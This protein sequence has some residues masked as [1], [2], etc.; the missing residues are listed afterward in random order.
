MGG[1]HE[2]VYVKDVDVDSVE[3]MQANLKATKGPKRKILARTEVSKEFWP[4]SRLELTLG[5]GARERAPK[6]RTGA[7]LTLLAADGEYRKTQNMK[8]GEKRVGDVFYHVGMHTTSRPVR[9]LAQVCTIVIRTRSASE[10][11]S[12]VNTYTS[13]FS[14]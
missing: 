10:I 11:P 12:W 13:I 4:V 7:V 8:S 14:A 2:G 9:Y 5:I 6:V 3:A 1:N